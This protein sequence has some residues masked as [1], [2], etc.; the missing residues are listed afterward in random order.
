[1][2]LFLLELRL[3]VVLLRKS[4]LCIACC[5]VSAGSSPV[6]TITSTALGVQKTEN[7]DKRTH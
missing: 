6:S 3:F 5:S 7:A 2:Y 4:K 1:M